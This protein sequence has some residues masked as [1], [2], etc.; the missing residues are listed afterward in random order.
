VFN[1][2]VET[3]RCK[4]FISYSLKDKN[5]HAWLQR[6]LE[7]YRSCHVQANLVTQAILMNERVIMMHMK[8][9]PGKNLLVSLSFLICLIASGLALAE[10]EI[11]PE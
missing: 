5:W 3:F 7:K 4:A 1:C 2:P 6:S 8:Q 11:R 9:Q 10:T